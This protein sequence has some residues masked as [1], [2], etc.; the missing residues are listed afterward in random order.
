M[1]SLPLLAALLIAS[2]APAQEI[3]KLPDAQP[4]ST[5][6]RLLGPLADGTPPPPSPPKP[7]YTTRRSDVLDSKTVS[8]GGRSVTLQRIKPLDLPPPPE[9][10]PQPSAAERAAFAER[11]ATLRATRPREVHIL[12]GGTLYLSDNRPPRALCRQWPAGGGEPVSFWTNIDLREIQGLGR[13][14]GTD[15]TIYQFCM[16]WSVIDVSRTAAAWTAKGRAYRPPA[17]PD[18]PGETSAAGQPAVLAGPATF[19][20]VPAANADAAKPADLTVI[21]ELHRIYN[22]ERPR[23]QAAR[24]RREAAQAEQAARLKANP[25]QPQNITLNHWDIGGRPVAPANLPRRAPAAPKR[26]RG[27][28]TRPSRPRRKAPARALSILLTGSLYILTHQTAPALLDSNNNGISDLVE[29]AWNGGQ[30]PA[31]AYA[32]AE[33]PDADG[34]T[35]QQEAMAGTDPFS[36]SP[37][38]YGFLVPSIEIV[39]AVYMDN[40]GV[41]ELVTPETAYIAWASVPGKAYQ[42]FWSATLAP[43]SWLEVSEPAV[44]TGTEMAKPVT[45]TQNNGG[46]PERL[47]F[48]VSITDYDTDGDN[49]TDH[50]ETLAGTDPFKPDSDDDGVRDFDEMSETHTNPLLAADADEDGIPDDLEKHLA[51]QFLALHPAAEYWGA[52]VHECLMNWDLDPEHDYTG[53]DI[54]ATELSG[55]IREAAAVVTIAPYDAAASGGVWIEFQSRRNSCSVTNT[56]GANGTQGSYYGIYNY[57]VPGNWDEGEVILGLGSADASYLTSRIGS[58]QWGSSSVPALIPYS[59]N[60]WGLEWL[61]AEADFFTDPPESGQSQSHSQGHITQNRFRLMAPRADHEPVFVEFLKIT[62]TVPHSINWANPTDRVFEHVT[63]ALP[64]GR[65]ILPWSEFQAAMTP[66]SNTTVRLIPVSLNIHKQDEPQPADGVLAKVGDTVVYQVPGLVP[67]VTSAVLAASDINWEW[68]KLRGDGTF[69]PWTGFSSGNGPTVQVVESGAGI[70]Q[71][72]VRI[73]VPNGS[74]Y[75]DYIRRVDDPH[76]KDSNGI[77]N[78]IYKAGQP[79][80]VGIAA[81]EAQILLARKAREYRG[82]Q[83]YALQATIAVTPTISATQGDN[84]CNVFIYHMATMS[85][86]TVPLDAGGWPPRAYDWYDSGTAISGWAWRSASEWA[87]PGIIVARYMDGDGWADYLDW[88]FRWPSTSAHCGIIDYDGAWINA[89]SKNVNRYP[90]LTSS[91]YQTANT[92]KN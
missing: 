61:A 58:L 40:N 55:V 6:S 36:A 81:G 91:S 53:D 54:P 28:K 2:G 14:A 74:R 51:M 42:V 86:A 12:L 13:F 82:S 72:R 34:W 90:H 88:G 21:T 65:M 79:D 47:F 84:K 50:E 23:L 60:Y 27:N 64:R 66:E 76:G 48:R 7:P 69:G 85:G 44:A 8:E 1:K 10:L 22:D 62:T 33:D 37:S 75:F 32:P 45:L 5:T 49:L 57:S 18:F 41:Q 87:E 78:P 30:M 68:R 83:A 77:M 16:M 9:P 46:V 29:T 26:R 67:L 70:F 92:R 56:P 73:D 63:V 52:A 80:Y 19:I 71:I 39:P 3:A 20:P 43:E 11:V 25:P 31:T 15:G 89:G 35:N 59:S 4:A 17:L 24:L 38:D